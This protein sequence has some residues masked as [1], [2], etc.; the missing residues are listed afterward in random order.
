MPKVK[1]EILYGFAVEFLKY[2]S[3][4]DVYLENITAVEMGFIAT[5]YASDY[6][7]ISRK[8]K[9]YGC[10]VHII[11]KQGIYFRLKKLH[12]RKGLMIG[13]VLFPLLCFVFSH[14]IWKIEIDTAD[15]AIKNEVA[16]RL[17]EENV[18]SGVFYS[19]DKMD[20][21]KVKIMMKSDNISYI[22]FNFYKGVLKCRVYSVNHKENYTESETIEN[23][24][25]S[26]SGVITDLRVYSGYSMVSPGQSVT[27]GDLLVSNVNISKYDYV[28]NLNT[29]AYIEGICKK[30]YSIFIPYTKQA[31]VY[32]GNIFEKKY[33][34]FM[35]KTFELGKNKNEFDNYTKQTKVTQMNILGFHLPI[36]IKIEI[37]KELNNIKIEENNSSA[38]SKGKTE[39]INMILK[40]KKL[41][42]ELNRRYSYR[43]KQ[44]G[45]EVKCVVE[46]CYEMI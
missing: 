20:D 12:R 19:Q 13:I 45:L 17:F 34:Y 21:L 15:L 1:F 11:K 7:S 30:E 29:A 22:A 35:G 25:A 14:I 3:D 32:T 8:A 42:K 31:Q 10:K 28:T 16:N 44:D 43:E 39:L 9:K 23:I 36:T 40:D 46:G 18:Y 37:F 2:L 4:N 5:C 24:Y 26:M 6:I 38:L 33:I 27:A 41:K